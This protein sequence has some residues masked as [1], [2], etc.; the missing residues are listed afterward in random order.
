MKRC[1]SFNLD[2]RWLQLQNSAVGK[3]R[4][5]HET[6]DSLNIVILDVFTAYF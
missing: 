5:N 4:H 2:S 3:V 6:L 1:E